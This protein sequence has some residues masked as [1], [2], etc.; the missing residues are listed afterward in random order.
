MNL[1]SLGWQ[2]LT[3]SGAPADRALQEVWL[4]WVLDQID[5][6]LRY[7][8]DYPGAYLD[9]LATGL[10]YCRELARQIGGPITVDRRSFAQD[11]TVH[12][13]FGSPQ[14]IVQAL[15]RSQDVRDW[16][17]AHPGEHGV[18]ALLGVRR[19]DQ[20]VLGMALN[21]DTVQ[22]EVPQTVTYFA[23]HSFTNLAENEAAAREGLVRRFM[24]SLVGRVRDRIGALQARRQ[25]LECPRNTPGAAM[26]MSGAGAREE[27]EPNDTREA[28][29][30]LARA[31]ELRA[32]P[33]H[34]AAVMQDPAA[35]LRLNACAIEVDPMGLHGQAQGADTARV[36]RVELQELVCRDRRVWNVF[37]VRCDLSEVPSY[38]ERL[39]SASRWLAI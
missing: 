8:P 18:F 29:A 38:G 20:H 21:H 13:L 33:D 28:L 30:D 22:R 19:Q 15:V 31:L 16:L 1:F 34:V 9:S 2:V 32:Y 12:A 17:R 7:M 25:Q 27:G 4:P 11:P 6:R 35:H 26:P 14:G 10:A 23:D 24:G 3:H 5:P 39:D 37:L 36:H